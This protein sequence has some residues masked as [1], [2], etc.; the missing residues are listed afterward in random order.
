M[1]AESSSFHA[2]FYDRS[3]QMQETNFANSTI[4]YYNKGSVL[5]LLLDLEIRGH[6]R[7]EKSLDDLLRL[8]YQQFDQAPAEGY[9]GPGHGYREEDILAAASQVAGS[10]LR[11]WFARFVQGTDELPYAETL[12]R[13]GLRLRV[14]VAPGSPPSLGVLTQRL[15][16]GLRITAVR[17]G[18]AADRAGLATGDI[19][20]AVDNLSLATVEL[21]DRLKI[22]PP[23]AEVPFTVERFGREQLV[24]VT[25]D[26]PPLNI[27][28]LEDLPGATAEQKDIRKAWL[29]PGK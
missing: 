27:Y 10:D 15:D 25:L 20:L 18:Q 23:G 7:G 24:T 8:L 11:T 21:N 22:Y 19:L 26:P 2:W 4:S 9:Y 17:P 1:S 29:A 3:P 16:R 14:A 6:T 28:A 5:G 13:A 12:A